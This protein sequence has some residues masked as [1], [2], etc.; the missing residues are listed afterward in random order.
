MSIEIV[1]RLLKQTENTRLEFKEA[2]V[3]LPSTL[4]E[5]IC[6]MLNREG[7][8]IVLGIDDRGNIIGIDPSKV[9]SM[10]T[11]LVNLS[12]NSQKLDPPFILFPLIYKIS[13]K[14][15]MHIQVPVSS[16]VHKSGNHVFD[17]SNDGDF[18]IIQPNRIAE[19][20]NRKKTH[21]TEGIIYP[22]LKLDDL[23]ADIFQKVRTLIKNNNPN[24]PWLSLNDQQMLQ[25]AG[26][27]RKDLQTGQ[28]G[29]TLAAALLFG[30]EETIINIL[31]HY[32][33]DALIRVNNTDRYDDRDYIQ[34][35]LINAYDRL[36]D[37]ITRHLPDKFYLEGDQRVSLRSKIFREIIA[38]ILVHREF[39]NA[40]PATLTIFKDHVETVNANVPNGIGPISV[41]NFA[42][43]PKNPAI[44]KFF[45]QLG[46][47]DELGSGILNVNKYL[48]AYSPGKKPEFIEGNIFKI[49]IPLSDNLL[50]GDEATLNATLNATVNATVNSALGDQV[51]IIVKE[52]LTRIVEVVKDIPGLRSK[53]IANKLNLNEQTIRKDI[54]K[55]QEIKLIVFKGTPKTGG[56]FISEEFQE[57]LS[58]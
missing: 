1:N 9:N 31:P 33:T 35:N 52:R 56:Y 55:L 11:E 50:R 47:V 13:G 6:A 54:Q 42:P 7:G 26:L 2:R 36:M 21:Y 41:K 53:A 8:D 16:Q 12:N 29:Y 24:H 58:E 17:R 40:F 34:S 38:N 5:T 45:I 27:W 57:K 20:Y 14:Y 23:D 28:E 10:K 51:G 18:K 39:T 22:F 19:L 3:A 37:F 25:T 44:A 48:G 43:F 30:K 46:L 15:L 4:F 49:I 32:K